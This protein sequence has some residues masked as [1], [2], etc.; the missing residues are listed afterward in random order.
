MTSLELLICSVLI[1]LSAYISASEVALFSLSRFQLRSLK[2]NFKQAHRRIKRLLGDPGGLLVTILVV[3]E[4]VNIAISTLIA[5]AVSRN[6]ESDSASFTLWG[7]LDHPIP[8]WAFTTVIDTL[9]ATPIILFF[10][11]ITPKVIGTRINQL[12][13]PLTVGGIL[14][15]YRIFRPIRAILKILVRL[16]SRPHTHPMNP[17]L[18]ESEF[19]M[20]LEEGH[21]EGAIKET[22]LELIR[23][24]LEL[25]NTSVSEISTPLSQ[26][27]TLPVNTTLSGALTA[28]RSQ[29]Y[30]R[31]PIVSIQNKKEIV[32][33]LHGKDLLRSKLMPEGPSA[34]VATLMRKPFFV[35][36]TT[37]LNLLF[38][39]LKEQR[40]HMAIVKASNGD[41]VGVVTMNAVL[42]AL[43]EDYLVDED[44]LPLIEP[45]RQHP[46]R[47][48]HS[49]RKHTKGN[50]P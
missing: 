43:F 21:K 44:D 7:L 10:C 13:A 36:P 28:M 23:N 15:I 48:G 19:L 30:S 39:K 34:S 46:S 29:R 45:V 31:I 3:T 24:V 5:G 6:L 12:V 47:A 4:I 26:L 27:L 49:N 35:S 41:A 25:D 38:R 1:L 16:I 8:E 32:G 14:M 11:E 18:K 2:E 50:L 42:E 22:E 33:V 37:Q 40:L 17:I 9:I 20:L